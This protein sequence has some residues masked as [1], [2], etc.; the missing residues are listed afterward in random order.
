MNIIT[1][2]LKNWKTTSAGLV[3]SLLYAWKAGMFDG[4]TGPELYVSIALFVIGFLAKDADVTGI[5]KKLPS[6][7]WVLGAASL[8]A[9][10][11]TSCGAAQLDAYRAVAAAVPVKVV[12]R[13]HGLQ[14]SYSTADGLVFYY[15]AD[16]QVVAKVA[17]KPVLAEK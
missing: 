5:S 1:N 8:A 10:G 3:M 11:L 15:D 9:G 12:G 14:A 7:V 6:M 16:G 13:Y 2:A 4:K 17:A